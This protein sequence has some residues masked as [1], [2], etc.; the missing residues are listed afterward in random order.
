MLKN[1]LSLFRA[2]ASEDDALDPALAAA[3]LMFEVVWADHDVGAEELQAMSAAL[4][5]LF[6]LAPQQI[7]NIIAQSRA[8]HEESVGLFDLTRA[9]NEQAD[10]AEKYGIVLALWQIAFADQQLDRFEEHMIR[11]VSEL[12]YVSHEDFIRAKLAARDGG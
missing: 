8:Q 10:A 4:E 7:D 3:G 1:L 6:G 11:R 9:I 5:Q 12:L 2:E